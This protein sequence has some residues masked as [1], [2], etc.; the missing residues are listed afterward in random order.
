MIDHYERQ[1]GEIRKFYNISI[2]YGL[3][4]EDGLAFHASMNP[5]VTF[6]YSNW[7]HEECDCRITDEIRE[8]LTKEQPEHIRDWAEEHGVFH[9]DRSDTSYEDISIW[10]EERMLLSTISHEGMFD[11]CF[12]E[13]DEKAFLTFEDEKERNEKILRRLCSEKDRPE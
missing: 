2:N 3:L 9:C 8:S 5:R 11:V 10:R 6:G 13:A 7:L 1:H 12:D 4:S